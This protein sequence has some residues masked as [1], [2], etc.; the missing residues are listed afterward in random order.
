MVQILRAPERQPTR[1]E[2]LSGAISRGLEQGSQLM[3]EYEVKEQQKK[4]KAAIS[5]LTGYDLSDINDPKIL[6]KAFEIAMQGKQKEG[7]GNRRKSFFDS[8]SGGK[9]GQQVDYS[10]ITDDQII[11]AEGAEKGLGQ[12]LRNL[13]SDALNRIEKENKA[14]TENQERVRE[15]ESV[16]KLLRETGDYDEEELE[17]L[18]QVYDVPTARALALKKKE[19]PLYEPTAQKLAAE[20]TDKYI[21]GVETKGRAAD[22]KVRGIEEG[23][24]LHQQ[25]ATGFKVGNW[26]AKQFDNPAL[27]DPGSKAFNAAMKSQYSGIGDIVKGKVSNFEFQTFQQRIATAEDSPKA[28]EC[29][30]VSALMEN[31]IAQKERDIV[32][33]KRQEYFDLGKSPGPNFDIEVQKELKPY[34]DMVLAQTNKQLLNILNPTKKNQANREVLDSIWGNP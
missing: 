29:L 10:Q 30:M 24:T 14:E 15:K 1:G 13:R 21:S 26:L 12:Q 22:E 32:D 34:A 5:K 28:A 11:E 6:E 23:M 25:G 8:I 2:K 4:Q 16:K 31:R 20:R 19:Q 18:S 9:Q 7:E 27:A 17:D 33:Q 3:Q